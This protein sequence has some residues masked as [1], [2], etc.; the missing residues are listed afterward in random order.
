MR[1]VHNHVSPCIEKHKEHMGSPVPFFSR[2][3]CVFCGRTGPHTPETDPHIRTPN[4]PSSPRLAAATPLPRR[5]LASS[6]FR[7]LTS[8]LR[9]AQNPDP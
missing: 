5:T 9:R 4:S 2:P 6:R 1:I 7:I 8:R 3:V